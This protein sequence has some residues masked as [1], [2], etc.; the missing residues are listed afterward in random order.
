[1]GGIC[2]VRYIPDAEVIF[3][4][5][6]EGSFDLKALEITNME[7]VAISLEGMLIAIYSDGST[8]PSTYISL[9]GGL[10]PREVFVICTPALS[11][12]ISGCDMTSLNLT[13]TGNDAI[14]LQDFNFNQLDAMRLVDS[15][16]I[17]GSN[18]TLR[19]HCG[20][21]VG[22]HGGYVNLDDFFATWEQFPE[23]TF[24]NLG[25]HCW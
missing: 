9:H 11:S 5:Y 16:E 23:N 14:E 12:T 21:G 18:V 15:D 19:R 10:E 2:T 17:W 25:M 3:T 1:M 24:D 7:S 4:E 20:Y 6:V 8:V 22:R 13:F